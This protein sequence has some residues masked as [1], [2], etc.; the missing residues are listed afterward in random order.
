[1][2]GRVQ[3]LKIEHL[4]EPFVNV[5]PH[6]LPFRS[7]KL[8]KDH[9]THTFPIDRGGSGFIGNRFRNAATKR[10]CSKKYDEKAVQNHFGVPPS[11]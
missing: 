5:T 9:I 8:E 10:Y 1:M 3:D 2:R 6:G 4:V 11:K 7:V